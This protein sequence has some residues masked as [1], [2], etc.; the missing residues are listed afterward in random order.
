MNTSAGLPAQLHAFARPTFSDFVDIVSGDGACITDAQGVTYIDAM[1]SLWFANVSYGRREVVAAISEQASRLH[2]YNT[3]EP[4][5]TR[6]TDQLAE[7]L[8]EI[9]PIPRSRV[10]FTNSGSEAVDTALKLARSAQRRSGNPQRDV[11][12]ARDG[13]Y[14]GTNYGGTSAQGI[15]PNR[16]GWGPLVPRI[17]HVPRHDSEALARAFADHPDQVAAVL[18][19]PVQGASGVHPPTAD[20][21]AATRRLCDIHGAYLIFDEVI[22]GFGRLGDWFAATRFAVQP[23]LI[24]FAKALT[25]GYV[26][27]GGVLVGPSV[28]EPLEADP[29]EMLRHGYTYSGHALASAAA[30]ACLEV[31]RTDDLLARATAIGKRLQSG[32]AAIV[33][34][35]LAN[36]ARGIGAVWAL[37]LSDDIDA[38]AVRDAAR[39]AGV[40]VRAMPAT[41][42]MCPPLVITD[43][44]VDT[45]LDVLAASLAT[46]ATANGK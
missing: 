26:P 42:A 40:I 1:A 24:T 9:S 28:R 13:G 35:G 15:V 36:E 21:L 11:V 5:T 3:F 39:A 23:D 6:P 41:L 29:N 8:V 27:M 16:E 38:V 7:A 33:A 12:I 4:F 46:C 14:H 45:V 22:T 44:Q 20:Y 32:L 2:A 25:S 31:T 18:T 30:L 10:F 19:E 34:D 37:G 17:I 43:E